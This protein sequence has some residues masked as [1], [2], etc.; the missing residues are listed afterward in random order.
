M[1]KAIHVQMSSNKER[2]E[3]RSTVMARASR[4]DTKTMSRS[5]SL[6]GLGT[7]DFQNKNTRYN[8][9][10]VKNDQ[11]NSPVIEVEDNARLRYDTDGKADNFVHKEDEAGP[12]DGAK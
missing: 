7:Q 4:S 11:T 10:L 12:T 2:C 8:E 3:R 1:T 6:L 9:L 5:S